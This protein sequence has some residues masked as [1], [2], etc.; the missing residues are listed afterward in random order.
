MT[1]GVRVLK[2]PN[3]FN[4]QVKLDEMKVD[5]IKKNAGLFFEGPFTTRHWRSF[6]KENTGFGKTGHGT[7]QQVVSIVKDND[8]IGFYSE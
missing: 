2:N 1:K 5:V 6:H 8:T 3:N 7:I 4:A